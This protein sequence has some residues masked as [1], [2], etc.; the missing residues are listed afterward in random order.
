MVICESTAKQ[1]L[2][3]SKMEEILKSNVDINSFPAIYQS[4]VVEKE[5]EKRLDFPLTIIFMIPFGFFHLVRSGI[6]TA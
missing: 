5:K 2:L 6:C 3:L 4:A 1:K